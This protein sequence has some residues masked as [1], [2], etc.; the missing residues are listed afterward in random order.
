MFDLTCCVVQQVPEKPFR[1]STHEIISV[2]KPEIISFS[3]KPDS[4]GSIEYVA[5]E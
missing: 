5:P 3:V 4:C 2:V 1:R